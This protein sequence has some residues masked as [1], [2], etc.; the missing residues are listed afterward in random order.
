MVH[1]ELSQIWEF[2][3]ILPRHAVGPVQQSDAAAP[4]ARIALETSSCASAR[5]QSKPHVDR[6]YRWLSGQD[7]LLTPTASADEATGRWMVVNFLPTAMTTLPRHMAGPGLKR[8]PAH[9]NHRSTFLHSPPLRT[10]ATVPVLAAHQP[11]SSRACRRTTAE[12]AHLPSRA[13]DGLVGGSGPRGWPGGHVPR[14]VLRPPAARV[15]AS[16]A[17][18]TLCRLLEGGFTAL[19]ALSRRPYRPRGR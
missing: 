16:R 13:G 11:L 7:G 5:S 9:P 6:S 8:S 14:S 2:V 19:K 12:A 1:A 15:V 4:T 3:A 17:M 18:G 10:H